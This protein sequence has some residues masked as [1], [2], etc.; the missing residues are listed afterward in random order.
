MYVID[1]ATFPWSIA[2]YFPRKPH[3]SGKVCGP[4]VKSRFHT[5]IKAFPLSC[6][7]GEVMVYGTVEYQSQSQ[8][9]GTASKDGAARA[10][11]R[12]FG[13]DWEMAEYQVC[14]G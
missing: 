12:M 5:P 1:A 10:E 7:S 8:H 13:D 9:G 11:L 3:P 6:Y 14:L 2:L 4:A